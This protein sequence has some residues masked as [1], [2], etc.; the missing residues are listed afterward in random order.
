MLI[1][2]V[3]VRVGFG[4]GVGFGVGIRVRVRVRVRSKSRVTASSLSST[5]S[6]PSVTALR[7]NA[8]DRCESASGMPATG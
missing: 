5:N 1:D 2:L 6:V 8:L 7:S 4:F 3:R